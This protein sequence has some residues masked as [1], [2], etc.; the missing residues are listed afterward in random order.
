VSQ[1]L[2]A[3]QRRLLAWARQHGRDLPWRHTRDPWAI[4]VSEV[5]LQQ[6]Q[7]RRVVPVWRAFLARFP[8]PA[9]CAAAPQADVVTAWHGMGYNRR[10]VNL[11]RCAVAI[12]HEHGG[13]VPRDL[14]QL[15]AL[16]G[17]GPYTARAVVVFAFEQP[18][19]VVDVNAARVHARL[20]GRS[21]SARDVQAIADAATPPSQ[22][23]SWNQ[24]VLDLGATVCT[25]K[26]PACSNCPLTA[27][28]GWRATGADPAGIGTR[29]S[30]FEGSDRQ[31]R[32]RLV[33]A[34]RRGAISAHPEV[35]AQTMGWPD[36]PERSLRV[37]MTVVADGLAKWEHQSGTLCLG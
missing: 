24:A 35:L 37:A 12:A 25:K 18:A 21:L 15:Q 6:T 23:W 9:A 1:G 5:M 32:G 7:V 16:P 8:T 36:D 2:N 34:L 22:A 13:E 20:A 11:H 26:D 19:G 31:G 4:L 27:D 29:Q 3:T 17:I 30:R 33:S 28:C 14:A 10:A